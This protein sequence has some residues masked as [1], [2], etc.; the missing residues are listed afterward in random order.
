M[1]QLIKNKIISRCVENTFVERID[2]NSNDIYY[3]GLLDRSLDSH[4]M[5]KGSIQDASSQVIV[6]NDY[7]NC[8]EIKGEKTIFA[9]DL[10]FEVYSLEDLY[11]LKINP[12]LNQSVFV[13]F[14]ILPLN[15]SNITK[16]NF[17]KNIFEIIYKYIV[18]SLCNNNI[19]EDAL[20][21]IANI[22]KLGDINTYKVHPSLDYT[23]ILMFN[24]EEGIVSQYDEMIESED[25][26]ID[27][28]V[29]EM[30]DCD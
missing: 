2:K 4:K 24:G 29:D 7:F 9:N 16:T 5:D 23:K 1:N 21:Y 25:E 8:F 3:S 15:L 22:T 18:S 12:S 13:E 6:F 19:I 20:N 10:C 26:M 11:N 30:I 27:I 14:I 28:E 17:N